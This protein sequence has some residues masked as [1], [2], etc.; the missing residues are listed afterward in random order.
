MKLD[1]FPLVVYGGKV[2]VSP[3]DEVKIWGLVNGRN[4]WLA[5]SLI[6]NYTCLWQ[7]KT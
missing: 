4:V 7:S 2:R 1:Y 6:R 5:T 3:L